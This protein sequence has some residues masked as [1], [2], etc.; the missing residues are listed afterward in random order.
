M[1]EDAHHYHYYFYRSP[2]A[3]HH[4]EAPLHGHDGD[5]VTVAIAADGRIDTLT[6]VDSEFS[7]SKNEHADV[8]DPLHRDAMSAY[9][10]ADGSIHRMAKVVSESSGARRTD[11]HG[12]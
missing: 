3:V 10:E 8:T 1:P 9:V 11:E 7:G 12:A 2:G 6:T 5:A 4:H